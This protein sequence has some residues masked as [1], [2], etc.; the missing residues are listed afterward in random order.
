MDKKI[1]APKDFLKKLH[2]KEHQEA[3]IFR[4]KFQN[5]KPCLLFRIAW[6]IP[7]QGFKNF[8]EYDTWYGSVIAE[9][10]N[11]YYKSKKYKNVQE[12]IREQIKLRDDGKMFLT[13]SLM[14]RISK[15]ILLR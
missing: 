1:T 7:Q 11:V 9:S 5:S 13:S 6:G 4:T 8:S 10:T 2:P 12:K 3:L 15:N 14:P